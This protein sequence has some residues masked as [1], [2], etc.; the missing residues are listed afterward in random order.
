[1]AQKQI[2]FTGG[3]HKHLQPCIL[4]YCFDNGEHLE[5]LNQSN[6]NMLSVTNIDLNR[7]GK[8]D[9]QEALSAMGL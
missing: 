1:M 2:G 6:I 3:K 7:T 8:W 4:F 5:L 9:K